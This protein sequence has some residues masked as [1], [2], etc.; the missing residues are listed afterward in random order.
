MSAALWLSGGQSLTIV[1]LSMNDC[2]LEFMWCTVV[3]VS[4]QEEIISVGGSSGGH[5]LNS[6]FSD[7]PLGLKFRRSVSGCE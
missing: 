3:K 7:T 6:E 5:F 4:F 2:T 1:N